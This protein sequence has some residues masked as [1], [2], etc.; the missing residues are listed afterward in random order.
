MLIHFKDENLEFDLI[1][2]L[3]QNFAKYSPSFYLI[4]Y[5]KS[6]ICST[7]S[8]FL[9]NNASKQDHIFKY[10]DNNKPT[11]GRL[12][13]D[14]MLYMIYDI[15]YKKGRGWLEELSPPFCCS[16][17]FWTGAATAAWPHCAWVRIQPSRSPPM[18]FSTDILVC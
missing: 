2:A 5:K 9:S 16:S 14:I 13:Y 11:I 10:Q 18:D 12:Q 7:R 17:I 15:F 3:I 6:S 8:G 4:Y 1:L